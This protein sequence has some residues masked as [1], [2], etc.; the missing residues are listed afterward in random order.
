MHNMLPICLLLIVAPFAIACQSATTQSP[1]QPAHTAPQPADLDSTPAAYLNGKAV[2]QAQLYRVLVPAHGGEALA[3]ILLERAVQ[4]RL[5]Q[6]G[7]ELQQADLDAE[8]DRLLASLNPDPDQAARLLREMRSQR[9]LDDKRFDSM[10]R[11][12]AGLRALVR[13]QVTLNDAAIE[14]AYALRY[15]KRYRVRLITADQL[16]TITQARKQVLAGDSFT[17]LAVD[18]STDTSAAQGGL[19]SP[20][21]PA[22]P[23]YPKAIRDALPK[24]NT[25]TPAKRLST[26]IALD[27]DYAL[28]WLED[29]QTPDNPPTLGAVRAELEAAVRRDLERLRMRQLARTLIEQTDIVILDPLLDQPWKRQQNAIENP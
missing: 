8:R 9:G 26:A 3:E 27:Q 20:I 22:D 2:T 29:I 6:E 11:T 17:D 5:Q 25:D 4:Q 24:L 19:L 1:G 21:S 15:G 7:S 12:N 23:T 18:L 13:D 10:L 28:L 14:Q 16:D